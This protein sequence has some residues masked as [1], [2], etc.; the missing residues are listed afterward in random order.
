MTT[1]PVFFGATVAVEGILAYFEN[2]LEFKLAKETVTN[3]RGPQAAEAA[4]P[5]GVKIYKLFIL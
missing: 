1:T 4:S 2:E 3:P 5:H